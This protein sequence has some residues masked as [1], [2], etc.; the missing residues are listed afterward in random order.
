MSL[1]D[2]WTPLFPNSGEAHRSAPGGVARS[3]GARDP[4]QARIYERL[5]KLAESPSAVHYYLGE[6]F[7]WIRVGFAGETPLTPSAMLDVGEAIEAS[8]GSAESSPLYFH[9]LRP[10]DML[11]FLER[12]D[13]ESEGLPPSFYGVP[14]KQVQGAWGRGGQAGRPARQARAVASSSASRPAAPNSQ[15]RRSKP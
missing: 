7:R 10:H 1:I 13:A 5:E 12:G 11:F 3:A 8:L 4:L 14:L 15:R 2:E 9:A 6:G